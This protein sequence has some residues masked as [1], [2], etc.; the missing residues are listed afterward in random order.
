MKR[1]PGLFLLVASLLVGCARAGS[2]PSSVP[3]GI[4]EVRDGVVRRVIG[5]EIP[6]APGQH[7]PEGFREEAP[8]KG[9]YRYLLQAGL[10]T[11]TG[12]LLRC[13]SAIQ[14]VRESDG[15]P[16]GTFPLEHESAALALA[17]P[18]LYVGWHK[19]DALNYL[20]PDGGGLIIYTLSNPGQLLEVTRF[21]SGWVHSLAVGHPYLFL[22][23][24]AGLLILDVSQPHRP[25]EVGRY[26]DDL[27]YPLQITVA[28]D[29]VYLLWLDDCL[30]STY[31]SACDHSLRALDVSQP[32]RIVEVQ[33]IDLDDDAYHFR[34]TARIAV[35]GRHLY[36]PSGIGRWTVYNR[37]QGAVPQG[38]QEEVPDKAEDR[39][40]S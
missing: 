28:D 24:A 21:N 35:V 8:R 15:A 25:R 9:D 29:T 19:S 7:I 4:V 38:P 11:G 18:H 39:Q 13:P 37:T 40:R 12:R 30:P 33:N 23:T 14:V 16:I 31:P 1:R 36:V 5:D 26:E 2:V 17:D 10:C 34:G 22:G 3:L 27:G 32:E 20:K 6:L